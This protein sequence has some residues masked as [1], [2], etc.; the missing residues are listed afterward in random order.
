MEKAAATIFDKSKFTRTEVEGVVTLKY[1]DEKAFIAGT[2][3]DEAT[4][5]K[6]GDY[7]SSYTEAAASVA[8]ELAKE[9]MLKHKTTER[10][11][12]HYPYTTS[13]RGAVDVTVDRSKTYPAMTEGADPVTKS[14]MRVIVTD[15]Y[16][17]VGKTFIKS[18]EADLTAA[19]LK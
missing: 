10:V 13:K 3:I 17:K 4:L 18:I 14:A 12:V 9:E 19:L 15:P 8:G 7:V 2:E 6:V 1:D 16:A 5:K 11:L